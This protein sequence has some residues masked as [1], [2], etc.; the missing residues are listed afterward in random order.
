MGHTYAPSVC[1]GQVAKRG[2]RSYLE[3]GI[4]LLKAAGWQLGAARG[5]LQ[6]TRHFRLAKVAHA[7]PEPGEHAPKLGRVSIGNVMRLEVAYGILP[8]ATH[9]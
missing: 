8:S 2:R 7:R 9:Q 6:Q 5:E 4:E 1:R 3:L